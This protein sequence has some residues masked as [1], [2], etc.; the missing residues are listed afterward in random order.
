MKKKYN[1]RRELVENIQPGYVY[2]PYIIINTKVI[3][4]D[5]DGTRSYWQIG[6]WMRFKLFVYG[7]FY[8]KIKII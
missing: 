2:A 1:P 5:E 7:L 6:Y 4:S 8:K 3:I